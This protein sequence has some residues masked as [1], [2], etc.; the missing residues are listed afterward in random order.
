ML[1]VCNFLFS[2]TCNSIGDLSYSQKYVALCPGN[3]NIAPH[4]VWGTIVYTTDSYLC[5]A[6]IHAGKI[7][8]K[9]TNCAN[10]FTRR[11]PCTPV[12]SASF[13]SE[14]MS[15]VH[16]RKEVLGYLRKAMCNLRR[17]NKYL[18]CMAKY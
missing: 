4:F 8:G 5:A 10:I 9:R 6:A 2:A 16:I 12:A 18:S 3:C 15:L 17:A 11:K 14:I 1:Y 7:A 13:L